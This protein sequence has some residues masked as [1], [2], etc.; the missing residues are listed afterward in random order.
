[1]KQ[2]IYQFIIFLFLI[3]LGPGASAQLWEVEASSDGSVPTARHENAFVMANGKFYLIGGRHNRPVNEYDPI[4][5]TWTEK[6]EPPMQMHH[7]QA[8]YFNEKIYIIGAFTGNFP[9]ETAL[10]NVY[11][12]DPATDTWTVGTEIPENRRRGSAG[13]VH[14]NGKI[15]V[16]G[17]ITN[18]HN[19]G[20]VSWFDEYDPATGTWSPLADAPHARDHFQVAV[21]NGKLVAA[22]G[23]TTSYATNELNNLTV[24]NADI[25]DFSTQTWTTAATPIPTPRGGTAVAFKDNEI[26]VIG[27]ETAS[28]LSAHNE[29]EAFNVNTQTW[30]TLSPLVTGRHATQA[31]VHDNK[32][33][34][35]AG[36]KEK[37]GN[38]STELTSIEVLNIALLT[39]KSDPAEF[40]INVMPNPSEGL[41]T[42]DPVPDS[43]YTV[44]ITNPAGVTVTT[45]R[46]LNGKLDISH[47]KPGVYYLKLQDKEQFKGM[48]RVVKH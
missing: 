32:V 11:I 34:I 46:S 26:L 15:Y 31:I 20:A 47:L 17:G 12:Y 1:M 39:G 3:F 7:F 33:Y 18:G 6:S 48:F 44:Q 27:G 21:A 13:A 9:D 5:K 14:H 16:V 8:V 2:N 28:Q 24:S 37:G 42:I 4:T 41:I 23:R 38:G 40:G 22:G 45:V 43:D 30:R 36:S 19:S 10:T 35:A 25:Y 29:T